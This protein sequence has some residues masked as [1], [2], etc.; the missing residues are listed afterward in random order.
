MFSSFFIIFIPIH[1]SSWENTLDKF[2]NIVN[3]KYQ[4]RNSRHLLFHIQLPKHHPLQNQQQ[5]LSLLLETKI[6]TILFCIPKII[7]RMMQKL[8]IMTTYSLVRQQEKNYSIPT[9]LTP[10]HHTPHIATKSSSI[11]NLNT[12][13]ILPP[14][15]K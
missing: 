6:K 15:G 7:S 1:Y 9:I 4:L 3:P 12:P 13:T 5:L 11:L 2:T 8:Q 10:N 14:V